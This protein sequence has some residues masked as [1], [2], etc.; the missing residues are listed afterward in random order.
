MQKK[1]VMELV[2]YGFAGVSTTLINIFVF[3]SILIFGIDY[4]QANLIALIVSKVYGYIIN[5]LFVFHSHCKN[6]RDLMVEIIS[7]TAARGFTGI[8]DFFGLILMV[9]VMGL[10]KVISKYIIQAIVIIL[11]YLFGKFVVFYKKGIVKKYSNYI[12]RNT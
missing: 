10:D 12:E 5:K 2:R 4:R 6:I 3:R 7:Y 1:N 11:N 9:E 8:V